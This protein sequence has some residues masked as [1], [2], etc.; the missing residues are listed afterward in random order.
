[1]TTSLL[2]LAVLGLQADAPFAVDTARALP[3]VETRAGSPDKRWILE[4]NGGG[5]VAGDFDG[6]GSHDLVVVDGSTVESAVAGEPGRPPRLFLQTE[7]ARLAPAP[8]SWNL[9]GGRFGMGGTAGDVEGDGDLDLVLTEWGP[10]RLV[11]NAGGEGFDEA[12]E[13]PFVGD[14]WSTSAAFFDLERDGDLDLVVVHYLAFDPGEIP[15]REDGDCSWKGQRVLCGPEGLTPIHDQLYRNDGQGGFEE[16][17][18]AAGFVPRA[19]GFGLGVVTLD[20]DLDGD[21]D[22]YVTND[23]TPN[24][25]WENLGDGTLREVGLRKGV[26]FDANGKEQAGMGI[27]VGDL[28][29]DGREDLFCTNFSGETNALYLSGGRARYRE[30]AAPL[31][32]GGPSVPLL[33]WGTAALDVDLDA[34][35]DLAV[36]N[37]HV[38]PQ[39]GRQGT[40]TSYAQPNLL[41][42]AGADGRFTSEPLG[43]A[44]P[45]VS[46]ALTWL[47][48][49][50]DGALDLAILTLDG[51]VELL[52][53]RAASEGARWLRVVLVDGRGR[54][55]SAL[56]GRVT[57]RAG[58]AA[59]VRE[60]RTAGGYQAAVPAEAHFG[61]GDAATVTLEVRWPDGAEQVVEDVATNRVLVLERAE[62]GR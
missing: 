40:D 58:D 12:R 50:D 31:G 62:E 61:L 51:P 52:R 41:H 4:V 7:D 46:R 24:H 17:A 55:R 27:A 34:D 38:Y 43:D 54:N 39:A 57:A 56:G 53:N 1:M 20:A 42:R 25:L 45:A 14:G 16:V 30:R 2:F 29:A 8:E 19:P 18:A 33:G 59:Q 49:G 23:S 28:D 10:D 60:I 15:A 11:R 26:A 48:L 47:D 6:D 13:S 5:L 21:T 32:V 9:A 44:P 3:G 37:G 35:L 22:L 36:V